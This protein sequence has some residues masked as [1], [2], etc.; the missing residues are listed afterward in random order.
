MAT[1]LTLTNAKAVDYG[2]TDT[3]IY[4]NFEHVVAMMQHEDGTQIVTLAETYVVMQTP[5]EVFQ[6]AS[7]L[8]YT[9]TV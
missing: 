5:S 8:T 9:R 7:N 1:L 4:I 3:A 2:L 6:L